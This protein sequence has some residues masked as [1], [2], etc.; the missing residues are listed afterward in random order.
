MMLVMGGQG[1]SQ[2]GINL[3]T[4][5]AMLG[6][7]RNMSGGSTG[8]MESD[9]SR[10]W[11]SSTTASSFDQFRASDGTLSQ[12]QMGNNTTAS[13][14]SMSLPVSIPESSDETG[15]DGSSSSASS[16]LSQSQL[17]PKQVVNPG[18]YKTEMCRPFNETGHCKYGEK[19]QFAHGGPEMRGLPR[20]PKYKTELCRTF[21]TVG[22]CP[23][24]PRCHFIHSEDEYKLVE[25]SQ[26]KH[27]QAAQQAA[28]EVAQQAAHLQ[29]QHQALE[30]Q[31]SMMLSQV[32]NQITNQASVTNPTVYPPQLGAPIE[33]SSVPYILG[34][35]ADSP[36]ESP[37]GSLN[38]EVF[39]QQHFMNSQQQPM[40]YFPTAAAP[41][42]MSANIPAI[43][44][45]QQ[46]QS[47]LAQQQQPPHLAGFVGNDNGNNGGLLI[48]SLASAATNHHVENHL[49]SIMGGLLLDNHYVQPSNPPPAMPCSAVIPPPQVLLQQDPSPPSSP[50]SLCSSMDSNRGGSRLPV[51]SRLASVTN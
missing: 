12:I 11:G 10:S 34:S 25:I 39:Q 24:G 46:I 21:H 9:L 42:H 14:N 19:C 48:E 23:Y 45:Q 35:A 2:T 18:R 41:H 6:R 15:R 5:N 32:Q 30:A 26:M 20:H 49:S 38:D 37:I 22:F 50:D 40:D 28:K 16:S 36:P 3:K 31:I 17:L 8:S 43:P 27:Q 29:A 7:V 44:V 4:A 51:F 33:H 13:S 47:M 1:V